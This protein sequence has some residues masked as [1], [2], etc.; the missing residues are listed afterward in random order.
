MKIQIF[1]K[2]DFGSRNSIPYDKSNT[3]PKNS[4][5]HYLFKKETISLVE[6]RIKTI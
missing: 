1:L 6:E 3:C 2:N 4:I 5:F